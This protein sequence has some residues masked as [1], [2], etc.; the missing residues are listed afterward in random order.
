MMFLGGDLIRH[1]P[2]GED[3]VVLRSGVDADGEFIEPAGWPPCR[4]RANDCRILQKGA[5]AHWSEI[6]NAQP[7]FEKP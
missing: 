4:A 3:W 6:K 7:E 2:T 1:K 5:Y